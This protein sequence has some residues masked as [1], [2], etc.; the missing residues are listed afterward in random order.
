MLLIDTSIFYFPYILKGTEMKLLLFL[1]LEI[2]QVLASYE[3][4]RENVRVSVYD[5]GY[6]GALENS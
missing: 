6:L 4:L 5:D 3:C 1:A 2:D